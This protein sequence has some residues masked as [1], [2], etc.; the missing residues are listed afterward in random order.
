VQQRLIYPKEDD[1][2]LKYLQDDGYPV[3]P[4]CYVPIIPMILVNGSK[5]IGTGVGS[6]GNSSTSSSS[7][8]LSGL[9]T[10]DPKYPNSASYSS[11]SNAGPVRAPTNNMSSS[12]QM[13][14][15]RQTGGSKKAAG[16]GRNANLPIIIEEDNVEKV[17]KHVFFDRDDNY[18]IYDKYLN[19]L[20]ESIELIELP[21]KYQ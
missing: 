19:N 12:D 6:G 13:S 17:L 7:R 21:K 4:I 16:G 9:N 2:V 3:E 1:L 8:A 20:P 10:S 15:N 5:G 18:S 14:L 11:R